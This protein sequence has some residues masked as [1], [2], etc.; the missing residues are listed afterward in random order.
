L[1]AAKK[2]AETRK[3]PSARALHDELDVIEEIIMPR[4]F[5]TDTTVLEADALRAVRDSEAAKKK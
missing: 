4:A 2:A 1:A 5:G 3:S